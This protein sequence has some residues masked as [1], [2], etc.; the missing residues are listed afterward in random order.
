MAV[1]V[2]RGLVL[3]LACTALLP[4]AAIAN[5]SPAAQSA[6]PAKV[7]FDLYDAIVGGMDLDAMA[8]TA[9][10]SIY[11]GMIRNEPRFAEA[12]K[13]KPQ[14]RDRF[15]NSARPYLRVWMERTT[16]VRRKQIAAK[17]ATK[18]NPAEAREFSD[19]YG[20][21]L[22]QK[23]LKAITQ[24][25]TLD[26]TVDSSMAGQRASGVAESDQQR[27]VAGAMQKLLPTLSADEQ[28][29]LIKYGQSKSFGKLPLVSEAFKETPEP[30]FNEISTEEEREAFK[31]AVFGVLS[32][33]LQGS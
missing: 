7:Y 27:T 22:G 11:D 3:A 31:K 1:A 18:L 16:T 4:G 29:Q 6:Q 32:E 30:S 24:N 26:A 17:L 23:L 20:S 15:R 12:A 14:L 21:P 2:I 13:G 25:L 28:R 5:G 19:L 33:A 9:A 8:D 10:D